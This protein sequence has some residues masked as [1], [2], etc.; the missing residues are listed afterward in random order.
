MAQPQNNISLTAP[1]FY[2]L[3]TQDSPVDQDIK[4]ASEATN[5]VL[6]P[7]GRVG[8]RKGFQYLTTN[9][10]ILAG[11]PI[12][13]LEEFLT[14]DGVSTIFCSGNLNIYVQELGGTLVPLNLPVGYT[15]ADDNWQIVPFN[16]KCYFVQ[17]GQQPLVYDPVDPDSGNGYPQLRLWAEYPN[18]TVGN[19]WP[20]TAHAAFGRL[21]LGDFDTNDTTLAW[22]GLLDG[23][24]W[25][26]LGTGDLQTEE[27]WPKGYDRIT[28]LGAH[29][30]FMCVYGEKNILLYTTTADVV[31]TLSLAD[32][33]E[34]IGCIARDSLEATG[35]DYLFIDATGLRSLNRTIQ[36]K[37]VPM[38][39]ISRNIRNVYQEALNAENKNTIRGFYHIEDS[40]YVSF[41]PNN[42]VTFVI[43]TRLPLQDGAGRATTWLET[44]LFCGVRL[45]TRE[46]FFGGA[47]GVYRYQGAID[48][49][50]VENPDNPG[51]DPIDYIEQPQQ[52][53][54]RYWTHF[55]DF[56]SPS[57]LL[58]PKQVDLTLIGGLFQIVCVNWSYDYRKFSEGQVCR[59]I[60]TGAQAFQ[61][62]EGYEWDEQDSGGEFNPLWGGEGEETVS[63][64][65]YNIWGSGRNIRI[66]VNT[67]VNGTAFSLQEMNIQALQ[68]RIL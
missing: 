34:G 16:D 43:D 67:N 6:D 46:T 15:I 11:N 21:W 37:S 52:I 60:N 2:G 9:P 28:A 53:P 54:F 20:N 49:G 25:S 26:N 7:F 3:N 29:N 31:S 17:T 23:E 39:D 4:F 38:G 41:F 50:I 30:N 36:E 22:S 10:E 1:G 44:Q 14:E 65:K 45:R 63:Q 47:N 18:A 64:I 66:G 8:S 56:G 55:L 27:Y 12:V 57:T 24:N 68:G 51:Q 13:T 48:V 40:F 61:W 35:H 58:F 62:N 33:I 42:P 19:A 59:P 5:C 32:T